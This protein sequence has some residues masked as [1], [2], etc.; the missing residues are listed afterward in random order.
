MSQPN[1]HN[2]N[3]DNCS[4]FLSPEQRQLLEDHLQ[5]DLS[6]LIRQRL[7]I[8]LL[9]DRGVPC[10]DICAELGCAMATAD[11]WSNVTREGSIEQ[12]QLKPVGRPRKFDDRYITR[13]KQ[14]LDSSP[15]FYGYPFQR[16][17]IDWLIKHLSLELGILI[18]NRNMKRLLKELGLSTCNKSFTAGSKQRQNREIVI[19]D[20]VPSSVDSIDGYSSPINFFSSSN[21]SSPCFNL[22]FFS[23][24]YQS[25]WQTAF[26]RRV[27]SNYSRESSN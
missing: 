18:S 4:Y 3:Q 15:V 2:L 13:L 23:P 20:L 14:L 25:I 19:Q 12:W 1:S 11:Y 22:N 24:S 17:T 6:G 9:A 10:L 21:G 26:R 7:Q 27:G 5:Q 16:W 8:M